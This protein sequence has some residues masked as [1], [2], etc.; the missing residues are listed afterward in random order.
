M[1]GG[2]QGGGTFHAG[3]PLL[4]SIEV[5]SRALNNVTLTETSIF[6][7]AQI[8]YGLPTTEVTDDTFVKFLTQQA[9]HPVLSPKALCPGV[10]EK[11]A[12]YLQKLELCSMRF[13]EAVTFAHRRKQSRADKA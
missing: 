1:G 10:M 5:N 4:F 8:L 7:F 3:L 12:Q 2:G 6:T 11:S 9:G 13:E